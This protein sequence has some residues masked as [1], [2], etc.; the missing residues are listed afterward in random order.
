MESSEL[1]APPAWARVQ[2]AAGDALVRVF[3]R[4]DFKGS[5]AFV[6]EIL[7]L[8]EAANHHP[9]VEINW[10][11]VTVTLSTHSE[12]GVTDKDFAL[13]REIDALV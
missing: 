9:D 10:K 5:V 13:A 7:P 11:D 12:G 1:T 8:A 3:D 4:G 6:N 2:T